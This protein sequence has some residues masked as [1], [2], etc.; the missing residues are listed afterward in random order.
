[1]LKNNEYFEGKVK[2]IAFDSDSLGA[3]SVG[4]MVKGE[5]TFGTAKPEEMTVVSGSLTVL[6]PGS[7]AGKPSRR[8]RLSMCPET[9]SSIFRFLK[10]AHT[11]ASTCPS[12]SG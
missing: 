4:V 6:L 5:Y 11:F 12:N 1:M 7:K 8:V 9:A 2:S 3:L 10:P